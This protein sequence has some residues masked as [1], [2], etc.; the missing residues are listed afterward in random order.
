MLNKG[1]KKIVTALLL[2]VGIYA[3]AFL[4]LKIFSRYLESKRVDRN[5]LAAEMEQAKQEA[6]KLDPEG[7][8]IVI[9][10]RL[11][12][13]EYEDYYATRVESNNFILGLICLISLGFVVGGVVGF[14]VVFI[15]S[16]FSIRKSIGMLIPVLIFFGIIWIVQRLPSFKLPPKPEDVTCKLNFVEILRKD[17]KVSNSTDDDG[18]TT[19]T[20]SYYIFFNDENGTECKFGVTEDSYKEIKV[21]DTC[22]IAS[23]ASEDEVVY[24]RNFDKRV[25]MLLRR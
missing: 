1:L 4:G 3:A 5:K 16:H 11:L 21:H 22:Y 24:Y 17:T 2:M 9:T 7:R 6:K 18:N 14:V 23:A 25:Y 20:V 8:R 15:K 19:S 12:K 13:A 10:E